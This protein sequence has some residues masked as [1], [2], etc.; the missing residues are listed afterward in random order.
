VN[1][2]FVSYPI[3][4]F[5]QTRIQ[6]LHWAQQFDRCCFFDN[7]QYDS[8][9]H[10]FECLLA[11][12]SLSTLEASADVAYAELKR[13]NQTTTDWLFGYFSFELSQESTGHSSFKPDPLGFADLSFFVP[14]LIV[15]L[16]LHQIRIG[17]TKDDHPRV[18]AEILKTPLPEST[19]PAPR[20][21]EI[22]GRF[23]QSEYLSTVENLRRH[24]L[25][26]DCYEINFCQE[27]YVQ[28]FALGDPLA[29]YLRLSKASPTPFAC[30]YRD[31]DKYLLC[32]SPE[33]YL[34]GEGRRIFSQPI[35]GTSPRAVDDPRLDQQNKDSLRASAK[36]LSENVMVVDLVRNDLSKACTA[37]SVQVDELCGIYSFA[38][39][40]HMISTVSGTLAEGKDWTDAVQASFP[41][42]SMTGAP[43]ARVLELIARY[44]RSKRGLF[45]GAVGYVRSDRDFDFNVVIRSILYN[46]S[47]QYLSFQVGSAITYASDAEKEYEE[48][49]LKASAI[50]KVL[51]G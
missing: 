17:S 27:F 51:I 3:S 14:L 26:G 30:F 7:H 5:Q 32:A 9:H 11:A 20:I 40:H 8:S 4:D 25:R 34:K 6:L 1:R 16:D 49:M 43:K 15:E 45:S 21:S 24:I 38:Q 2:V 36:D 10:Q 35:K 31:Q 42:G 46:Q 12:G 50:K 22:R 29:L 28:P 41:M 48:C 19:A 33:R 13:F 18:L 44:E 23:T 47:T 37:G 39:V